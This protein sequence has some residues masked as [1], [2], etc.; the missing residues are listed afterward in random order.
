M[1]H[2]LDGKS[3]ECE[4]G[5]AVAERRNT[6]GVTKVTY[7]DTCTWLCS[8]GATKCT[9][10]VTCGDV[11]F[12][13]ESKPLVRPPRDGQRPPRHPDSLQVDAPLG[14]IA[15]WLE[16][17]WKRPVTAPEELRDQ[18]VTRKLRGKPEEI[19]ARLGLQLGKRR[20]A[21]R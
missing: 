18:H 5:E 13:G 15:K 6:C 8:C 1:R 19:A 17:T 11:V 4:K 2:S 20:R 7:P 14:M 12:K 10:E 9:W 21:A 16:Q 3:G